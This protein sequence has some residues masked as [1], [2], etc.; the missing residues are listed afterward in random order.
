MTREIQWVV[1][2]WRFSSAPQLSW[3]LNVG[4]K[5]ATYQHRSEAE[6]WLNFFVHNGWKKFTDVVRKKSEI[7]RYG[8][9]SKWRI[10]VSIYIYIFLVFY[11]LALSCAAATL[12]ITFYTDA[13]LS[14]YTWLFINSIFS[15]RQNVI[16]AFHILKLAYRRAWKWYLIFC[17]NKWRYTRLCPV[18]C[19]I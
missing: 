18:S 4:V 13:K 3:V 6:M 15:L 1:G 19:F 11:R 10:L 16:E 7:W 5:H 2:D 9:H 12:L 17:S 8:T 14:I